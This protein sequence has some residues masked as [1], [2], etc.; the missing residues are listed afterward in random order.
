MV[1][2]GQLAG[3]DHS[4]FV[5][6]DDAEARRQVIGWLKEWFGWRDVIELGDISTARGTE[7]LLPLWVRTWSALNTPMFSFR[8]VR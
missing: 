8:V 3:G 1:D 5:C 4:M 7:M 6:G 2:P